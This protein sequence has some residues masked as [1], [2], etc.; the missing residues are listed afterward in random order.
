MSKELADIICR[1]AVA[2][3]W[4]V[5]IG[6]IW[7]TI[8]WLIWRKIFSSKPDWLQKLWGVDMDWKEIQSLMIKFMAIGKMILFICMLLSLWLTL[9]WGC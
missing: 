8:T 3:W 7:L 2:G 4:T 9:L 6:V 5:A 1:A